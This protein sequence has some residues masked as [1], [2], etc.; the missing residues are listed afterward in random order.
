MAGTLKVGTIT[1]PTGSGSITI[2]SG[3][4]MT[5]H[6]SPAFLAYVGSTQNP[7]DST[8]TTVQFDTEV[9]DTNNCFDTST[10]TFTPTVAGKY[11]LYTNIRV[12]TDSGTHS[13]IQIQGRIR[14]ND[15]NCANYLLSSYNASYFNA[16]NIIIVTTVEANGASDAFKCDVYLDRDAGT[17]RVFSGQHQS[18]FG[19]YRIGD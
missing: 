18:Y 19:G 17:N 2:P 10:Y 8:N 6:S 12:D 7:A 3:V 11:Y 1:T 5:G 9:F 15:S 16:N 4:A 14:K 13:L